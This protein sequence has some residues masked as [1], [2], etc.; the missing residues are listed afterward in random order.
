MWGYRRIRSG[1][2]GR[3]CQLHRFEQD[4]HMNT[5]GTE[6]TKSLSFSSHEDGTV[7]FWNASGTCLQFMYK[8]STSTV[9][10]VDVHTPDPNG[11]MEEE[12]PPFRK[13]RQ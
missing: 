5:W 10:K 4:C 13:V 1:Y 9:F 11:E 3:I 7:R 12:W 2:V 8:L 6:F